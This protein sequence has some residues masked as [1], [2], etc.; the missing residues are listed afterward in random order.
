MFY[1][2]KIVD[3]PPPTP[4]TPVSITEWENTITLAEKPEEVDL[5]IQ[6]EKENDEALPTANK[7]ERAKILLK[8]AEFLSTSNEYSEALQLYERVLILAPSED[9]E[10]KFAHIAYKAKKFQKSADY[11]KKNIGTLTTGEK[12]EFLNALRY[13][14]DDDFSTTLANMDIPDYV[15]TAFEVSWKCEN[16]FIS[17]ESAIRWY[18]YDY[19]PINDLKNALKNYETLG[20]KDSNYKEALLIW[21]WYKNGDYMNVIKIGEN[22]LRRKPDY[23][24]ILKIVGFSSYTIWAYGRSQAALSKYKK[25]EPKDPEVDFVL[26]LINFEKK[27]YET[28]NIYFNNAVLGGYKPKTVVERKLAYNYY[29]LGL[30][31]NMFQVLWYLMIE[32]DITE[33]DV[34]NA[35]FLALSHD[36]VRSAGEWIKRGLEK[37][38]NSLELQWLQAWHYRVTN[39]IPAVKALLTDILQKN[40]NHLLGL[41]ES[42]INAYNEG[43][44][45]KAKEYLTKAEILNA[46]GSWSETI[47][48]YLGRL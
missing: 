7:W 4:E 10:R 24:P 36:E 44:T 47:N 25:L 26:G 48:G 12:I 33:S 11:Y 28:S 13:T 38:P 2:N 18:K 39:N 43:D 1:A 41:I 20:N 30:K 22:L 40:P 8:K 16:E 35:V 45:L 23:R 31:K 37:F 14:G 42:G 34:N 32:P 27:D 15:R 21:A 5:K 46:G 3:I 19:A 17:C 9:T 29:V 6:H